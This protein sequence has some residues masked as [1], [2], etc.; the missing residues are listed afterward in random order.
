MC[1]TSTVL[2]NLLRNFEK[3]SI[4]QMI[5]VCRGKVSS[6]GKEGVKWYNGQC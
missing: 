4:S 2:K 1:N 6:G 5:W 3:I